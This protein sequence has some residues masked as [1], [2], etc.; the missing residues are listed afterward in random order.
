MSA[1][2]ALQ[3]RR[4]LVTRSEE[5]CAEWAAELTARG[6]EPLILPCIHCE[7][8]DTPAVRAAVAAAL[9][10][11]DWLVVTSR[12]GVDAV[13]ALD[14]TATPRPVR[15]R[16][17][18]V[19]DATAAAARA[20][21]GRC[22]FVGE[23]TGA[24]LATGLV[25]AARVGAGTNVAIAVA[26]NA[27]TAL[28]QGL[29]S[30]GATCTRIDVYRTVPVPRL[31]AKRALSALGADNILLA[32][33]SAVAGLVNQVVL[34]VPAGVYTIGPSTTAAARAA[35]L[36]VTAQARAP[37]LEGLLEAMQWQN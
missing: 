15:C 27:A 3:G 5:D 18:A 21:L 22:D 29:E 28:E 23:G 2:P 36:T 32:S 12:R 30:A 17:A 10:T 16:V 31:S 20:R 24:R 34:D 37:S 6:A 7:R 9:A 1:A 35:G 11:A 8:I 4:V 26:A 19:G 33:P 25:A 13:A 14:D